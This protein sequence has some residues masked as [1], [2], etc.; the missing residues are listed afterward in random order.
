MTDRDGRSLYEVLNLRSVPKLGSFDS[1]DVTTEGKDETDPEFTVP[2]NIV[3][4]R[5]S[6]SCPIPSFRP[7]NPQGSTLLAQAINKTRKM[8]VSPAEGAVRI[9]VSNWSTGLGK[10][11][12][13]HTDL[14]IVVD[15][16]KQVMTLDESEA[17]VGEGL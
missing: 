5:A 12:N 13:G 15:T 7:S 8:Y 10:D 1:A 14:E 16:L 17:A 6:E 4:F 11:Q 2:L 9:A 3:L